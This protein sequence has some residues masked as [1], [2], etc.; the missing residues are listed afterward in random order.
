MSLWTMPIIVLNMGGEMVYIL[1][2]RLQAQT[3]Q[4]EKAKK[5]LQDVVRAMFS[6]LFII[7]LFKAQ[8]M[9]STASTKQIFE[10]L[11]HSS[12][13]RLNKSSM[14]K[15]YDLMTMGFKYQMSSCASPEQYMHVTLN[16]LES[17]KR[18]IRQTTANG[19]TGGVD[20]L[21]DVAIAQLTARY[22][23]M[24]KGQFHQLRI[25]LMKFL[26]GKKVKVSLFL[27]QGMQTLD[28]QLV[29]NNKGFMPLGAETPG[30]V[31]FYDGTRVVKTRN[32]VLGDAM[33]S[34]EGD[35][36]CRVSDDL[37]DTTSTLG[38]NL[39]SK[40]SFAQAQQ[41]DQTSINNALRALTNNYF[42]GK[43]YAAPSS[44]SGAKSG[45]PGSP[46]GSGREAKISQASAKAELTML[47][48][49]LGIGGGAGSKDSGDSS[50]FK[51]NLF[52]DSSFN[53][54]AKGG[55]DGVILIDI[56]ASGTKSV[57]SY[58]AELGFKDG[59]AA[60]DS[61]MGDDEDDDLLAMM[62]AAS[63]K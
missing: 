7:E 62:D 34:E 24:S 25:S 44:A 43:G 53:S 8:E 4:D 5:V 1:H 21:V 47:S 35:Q 59:G 45:G 37:F 3:V 42:G 2:Q 39:F 9:Y 50:D 32:I 19:N 60:A 27:Q 40:D 49:L 10:K 18:I 51:I 48:D 63:S 56:D 36:K 6:P 12:I 57:E 55:G 52:P 20:D 61:K 26:Q 41:A 16:H 28:G 33:S 23:A 15:L 58:M 14:D 22:S 17:I 11:A 38:L 29:L 31:R 13:M 54:D 46:S 30:C